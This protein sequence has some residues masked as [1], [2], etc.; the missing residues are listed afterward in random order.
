MRMNIIDRFLEKTTKLQNGCREWTKARDRQGYGVCGNGRH[1]I[2]G[3][4]RAH[5]AAY[6]LFKGAIPKGMLVLH[7]CDNASC[8]NPDHLHL[9]TH[10]Q[11]Q[12]EKAARKRSL[13]GEQHP[14]TKLTNEQA[15]AIYKD[16][17]VQS[18]IAA[19]YGITQPIVAAIKVGKS[20]G[21]VTGA[22]WKHPGHFRGTGSYQAKFS[23][24]QINEIRASNESIR[25]LADRHHVAYNT[26]RKIVQRKTYRES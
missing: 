9:G 18:V 4:V 23:A 13:F 10:S 14:K 6:V 20:W 24:E 2:A 15:L 16:C 26:M 5:R 3:E 8:V 11:N 21:K 7:S 25:T 17:R 19:E 1:N 12:G 22:T